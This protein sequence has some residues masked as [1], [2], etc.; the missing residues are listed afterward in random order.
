MQPGNHKI[1]TSLYSVYSE[2]TSLT[3][4]NIYSQSVQEKCNI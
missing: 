3:N 4:K 1:N 2:V